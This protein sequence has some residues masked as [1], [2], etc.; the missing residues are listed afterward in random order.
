VSHHGE[1]VEFVFE[2]EPLDDV[3]VL[4]RGE[5]VPAGGR[6]QPESGVVERDAAEA[7]A[8][9]VDDVAVQERP[10][11]VAVQEQD[12]RSLA[13]VDVVHRAAADVHEPA[14]EREQRVIH[15]VRP[16]H[17]AALV[18]RRVTV[19]LGRLPP[20][21]VANASISS[22]GFSGASIMGCGLPL[23]AEDLH[24]VEPAIAVRGFDRP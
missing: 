24:V 15:P 10:G 3:S 9:Q 5:A 21:G 12:G 16:G 20:G 19:P 8:Q 13:L 6:R 1:L 11:R 4:R 17:L 14:F 2:D 7:V 23:Q 22:A 18:A